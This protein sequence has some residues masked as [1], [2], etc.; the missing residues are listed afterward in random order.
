MHRAA[1]SDL[2]LN[3]VVNLNLTSRCNVID[4]RKIFSVRQHGI[5]PYLLCRWRPLI[6]LVTGQPYQSVIISIKRSSLI[7]LLLC[8]HNSN[9]R[10]SPCIIVTYHALVHFT[11]D[12]SLFEMM[13]AISRQPDCYVTTLIKAPKTEAELLDRIQNKKATTTINQSCWNL[14]YKQNILEI[15]S[16]S[17]SICGERNRANLH[18]RW[19]FISPDEALLAL[20]VFII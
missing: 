7:Y 17:G 3:R 14:A 12:E 19:P 16:R 6:A 9:Q 10:E 5:V 1:G 15:M 4:P 20:S 13:S 18:G 2:T 8:N 11:T